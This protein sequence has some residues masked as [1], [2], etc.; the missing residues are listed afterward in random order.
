LWG[1]DIS[2]HQ[3]TANLVSAKASG[4]SFAYIKATEGLTYTDPYYSSF[5]AK[6]KSA[7]LP[8]GA[9]HFA[10]PQAGRTGTDEARKFLS[11]H[12]QAIGD[13]PP[14]LDLEDTQLSPAATA[15][16]ALEWLTAVEHATGVTPL[17]YT[18]SWFWVPKVYPS[19]AFSRYP[20]WL[21]AYQSTAPRAPAPWKAWSIWQNSSS[22]QVAGIPGNCDHNITATDYNPIPSGGFLSDMS[23]ANQ[24][25][26]VDAA[27]RVLAYGAASPRLLNDRDGNTIRNDVGYA[28]DQILAAISGLPQAQGSVDLDAL[29]DK[30]VD[31]LGDRLKPPSQ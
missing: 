4:C 19:S 30:V 2:N 27:N 10:H 31:R 14:A 29:A 28:R 15:A 17:V 13:L 25:K 3:P 6:A 21:S 20:L 7:G 12:K 22:A 26:L 5:R 16:F 9:Y 18:G 1:I 8:S 23:D 24:Q 11:V